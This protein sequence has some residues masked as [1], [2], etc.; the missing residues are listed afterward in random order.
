MEQLQ[1]FHFWAFL[2]IFVFSY[3]GLEYCLGR[4]GNRLIQRSNKSNNVGEGMDCNTGE[5]R[6]EARIGKVH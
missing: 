2:S 4:G 3:K 1:F 6:E 5:V